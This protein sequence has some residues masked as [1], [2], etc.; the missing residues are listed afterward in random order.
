M[1][2]IADCG[3]TKTDWV[4]IDD[5]ERTHQY[6]T[7]GFNPYFLT[8]DEIANIIQSELLPL[9]PAIVPEQP[10]SLFFYGAGCGVNSKNEIVRTALKKNFPYAS[11]EIHN[12]L[13]G[14]ARAVFGKEQGIAAILGTGSNTC[15]YDGN[16]I[17]ENRA[18]LGYLLGDEGSGA[19]ISKMFIQDYLNEEMPKELANRFYER[20][21]LS[22]DEILDSVYNKPMP[23]RFLAS[24]SIFINENLREQY[25]IDLVATCFEQLFD[26]HICKYKK[27]KKVKLNCVG[28]VA[29][30]Y[31]DLLR[32]VASHKGVVIDK[33]VVTPIPGLMSYHLKEMSSIKNQMYESARV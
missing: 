30:H 21:R 29:F 28:S 11:I 4:L 9:L 12:D 20:F 6:T 8:S 27:Y 15:Y 18:S 10:F 2:L 1:I 25:V 22:L 17:A 23:N 16:A 14:A 33:I 31:G 5:A 26:T 19:H 7:Q 3:S 32:A 24:F 13:L